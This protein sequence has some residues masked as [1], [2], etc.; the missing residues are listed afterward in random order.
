LAQ[1]EAGTDTSASASQGSGPVRIALA[2][3]AGYAPWAATTIASCLLS[4]P[5]DQVTFDVLH[6]STLSQREVEGIQAVVDNAHSS[7]EF[8]AVGPSTIGGLPTTA[9]FGTVVWLRFYLPQI[10]SGHRK[11]L[12]LDA[13]TFVAGNLAD[14]WQTALGDAPLAAVANVVEPLLRPHVSD[15]GVEYPG[16]FFNSGVLLLNLDLMRAEG[17]L[18]LLLRFA[19]DHR[20]LLVWPDQD[21]LNA[22]FARRWLP[23]HPRFNAQS[24]LWGW[25]DWAV[26]VY[27]E[28][29]VRQARRAPV[30]RHFEGRGL[31]K[32]WHYMC[33]APGY[34]EYRRVLATTPWANTP[35]EDRTPATRLIRLLPGDLQLRAYRRLERWRTQAG[36]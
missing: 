23:L 19:R 22:V 26:E 24:C 15:L 25:R 16:G 4:N 5:G 7:I 10:L 8:H 35:I 28:D 20:E 32:P 33:P 17:S 34:K 1:L 14:L 30:I 27:G 11:V 6:A 31:C 36:G 12:Y 21:A 13:D 29:A 3:D 18:D 9:E 2:I